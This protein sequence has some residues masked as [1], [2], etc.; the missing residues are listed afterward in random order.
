[1]L[2]RQPRT[3]AEIASGLAR[4]GFALVAAEETI[5]RLDRARLLDDAAVADAV[6]RDAG[7]RRLG[8]RRVAVQ[9]ARRGVPDAIRGEAVATSAAGD[10]AAAREL[11]ARRY[12]GGVPRD[13]REVARAMRLLA[14]RGFSADAARRALGIDFDVDLD[15]GPERRAR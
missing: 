12:P 7:R 8:S 11:L 1:M 10:A 6:L 9:L 5:A 4:R 15:D 13:R 14:G 3:A 2:A